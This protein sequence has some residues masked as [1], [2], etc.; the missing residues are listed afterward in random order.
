MRGVVADNNAKDRSPPRS[1]ERGPLL[2]RQAKKQGPGRVASG[3]HAWQGGS[4]ARGEM[5][6]AQFR[7]LGLIEEAKAKE[8]D[9]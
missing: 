3:G 7:A 5:T 4:R 2:K 9:I 6:E 1:S 8:E